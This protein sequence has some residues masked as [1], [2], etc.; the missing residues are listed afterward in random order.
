MVEVRDESDSTTDLDTASLS[1]FIF[2]SQFQVMSFLKDDEISVFNVDTYLS[3]PAH[4]TEKSS[5][6]RNMRLTINAMWVLYDSLRKVIITSQ[7]AKDMF[8]WMIHMIDKD[9]I[10]SNNVHFRSERRFVMTSSWI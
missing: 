10:I 2:I 9:V 6:W 3:F 4:A 5:H 8:K 7:F 1:S